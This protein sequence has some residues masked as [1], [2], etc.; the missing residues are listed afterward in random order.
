MNAQSFFKQAQFPEMLSSMLAQNREQGLF[1]LVDGTAGEKELQHFFHCAPDAD[2]YPL[3]LGTDLEHCLPYSPYLAQITLEHVDFIGNTLPTHSVILFTSPLAL[4][5]QVEFWRNRLYATLPDGRQ[6]LF[7]Y[8][9]PRIMEPYANHLSQ[10]QVSAFLRPATHLITP[11]PCLQEWHLRFIQPSSKADNE[12]DGW[13]VT[14]QQVMIFQDHFLKL[15]I[16]QTETQLWAN[17][18]EVMA[19]LHPAILQRTIQTGLDTGKALGL[20]K[21]HSLVLFV[22][23]QLRWGENFWQHSLFS[24]IWHKETAERSFMIQV[25]SLLQV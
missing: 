15:Q 19:T 5:D 13:S 10:D 22:E 17:I 12:L 8:W 16:R 18:P 20:V 7:R 4:L 1:I 21:D 24:E 25:D 11:I 3:F 2:Y 23:S 9:N 6:L 14:E